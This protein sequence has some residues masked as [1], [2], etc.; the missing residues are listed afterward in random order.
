MGIYM[1]IFLYLSMNMTDKADTDTT[2]RIDKDVK[3]RLDGM[4]IIPEEPVEKVIV[5]LLDEHDKRVKK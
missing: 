4:K 5:R 1:R 3:A 2:I